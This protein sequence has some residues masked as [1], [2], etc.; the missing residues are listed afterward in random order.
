M[1]TQCLKVLLLKILVCVCHDSWTPAVSWLLQCVS[2]INALGCTFQLE[3]AQGPRTFVV[4]L[5]EIRCLASL[6]SISYIF[7]SHEEWDGHSN[8]SDCW[9]GP[10]DL[11]PLRF[12]VWCRMY[13]QR[14]DT[15]I[16]TLLHWLRV[17]PLCLIVVDCSSLD[18][19]M[20]CMLRT[21]LLYF[22]GNC[23]EHN[24][25]KQSSTFSGS[26]AMCVSRTRNL[27]DMM[28]KVFSTVI[29]P[30]DNL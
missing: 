29:Q 24:M 12:N 10:T 14:R 6:F 25:P 26:K 16:R 21:I 27:F 30:C 15:G 13:K 5:T 1:L 18:S 28:P 2:I 23:V 3:D 7:S 9:G 4:P 17:L 11:I 19:L 8:D 20:V 22:S